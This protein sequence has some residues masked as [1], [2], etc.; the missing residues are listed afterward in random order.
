[1]EE[2]AYQNLAKAP[3]TQLANLT[4][5][6]A[7]SVPRHWTS[8][9]LPCGGQFVA[10]HGSRE[11]RLFQLAGQPERAQPWFARRPALSPKTQ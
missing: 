1:M 7:M 2:L 5:A 6:P 9:G 10:P 8:Q 3:Y 4:G 11:G